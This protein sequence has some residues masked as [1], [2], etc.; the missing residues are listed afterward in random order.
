SLDPFTRTVTVLSTALP[1]ARIGEGNGCAWFAA[2]DPALGRELAITD[3]TVAG[4]GTWVDLRPGPL[5]THDSSPR[6][7]TPFGRRTAFTTETATGA[8]EVWITD[9]T[10]AGTRRLIGGLSAATDLVAAGDH[11]YFRSH[12]GPPRYIQRTYV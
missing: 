6:D 9:G 4:T 8:H 11:L 2:Q 5:G 10:S 12:S 1:N 3:G 7:F